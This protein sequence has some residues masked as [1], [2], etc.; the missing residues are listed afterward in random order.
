MSHLPEAF[1]AHDWT[2]WTFR[3]WSESGI[4]G[5]CMARLTANYDV[6][7]VS[8]ASDGKFGFGGSDIDKE[9]FFGRDTLPLDSCIKKAQEFAETKGGWAPSPIGYELSA[10]QPIKTLP[11]LYTTGPIY[12]AFLGA[13]AVTGL[14][15]ECYWS[16][17]CQEIPL[18]GGPVDLTHWMPLPQPPQEGQ[19]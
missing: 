14:V 11:G 9:E 10:W 5:Y 13:C 3:E 4:P 7:F 19:G 8:L 1:R 18:C 16:E 6:V 17:L 2:G 12:P 15:G